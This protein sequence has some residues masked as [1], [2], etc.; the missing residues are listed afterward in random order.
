VNEDET[1]DISELLDGLELEIGEPK[2]DRTKA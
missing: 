1:E 2:P